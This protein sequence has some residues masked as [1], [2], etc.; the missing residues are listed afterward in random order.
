MNPIQPTSS[1]E[2]PEECPG[3]KPNP[4]L[5]ECNGPATGSPGPVPPATPEPSAGRRSRFL[6]KVYY[7]VLSRS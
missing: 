3:D 7:W 1:P 6:E 5:P 4:A 2:T